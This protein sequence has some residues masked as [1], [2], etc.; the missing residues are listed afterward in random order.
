MKAGRTDVGAKAAASHTGGLA[1][2]DLTT[3]L[4]FEKAGI[5]SFTDEGELCEAAACVASQPIPK[6]N[7]VG[8]ITNTGGPAVIGDGLLVRGG[9]V[10]PPLSARAERILKGALYPEASIHNRWT[11]SPPP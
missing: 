3:D 6:G 4:L 8:I 10:I 9:L 11:C 1:K 5:L 7:R 2:E